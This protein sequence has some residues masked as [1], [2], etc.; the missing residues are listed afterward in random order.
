[1]V[2]ATVIARSKLGHDEDAGQLC[3]LG[4][5]LDE[6]RA[7][8]LGAEVKAAD[9]PQGALRLIGSSHG[10][11]AE[12][13]RSKV[14]RAFLSPSA[15]TSGARERGD[16][17]HQTL[18]APVSEALEEGE[19][20]AARSSLNSFFE[21]HGL[22]A[23]LAE[24]DLPLSFAALA[25]E[26]GP[27]P[28]D[29][30]VTV[31]MTT[32]N[33]ES[34]IQYSLGSVLAQSHRNLEVIVVDDGSTD[35][36]VRLVDE[37]AIRDDRVTRMST[38]H[39]SGTYAAKNLGLSRST[40]KYFTC[41]DSD[42]WAH[43][44]RIERHL[45]MMLA[46]PEVRA[47]RSAWFRASDR[48]EVRLNRWGWQVLEPNASS[49]FF[50]CEVAHEI[51]LFDEV[52]FGADSEY[53]GRVSAR[54]GP[55]A[56]LQEM[57]P[58]AVGLRHA[59][60]LTTSGV[61]AYDPASH[62]PLRAAYTMSWK[63]WHWST[64]ADHLRLETSERQF[65]A[66]EAMLSRPATRQPLSPGRSYRG[67]DVPRV[68]VVSLADNGRIVADPGME[69][70]D[71]DGPAHTWFHLGSSRT[72]GV[73]HSGHDPRLIPLVTGV[74]ADEP[75]SLA[76]AVSITGATV[77]VV[78]RATVG[79]D[80]QALKG[81]EAAIESGVGAGVPI[82]DNSGAVMGAVLPAPDPERDNQPE[83]LVDAVERIV[84]QW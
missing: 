42:D 9:D 61:G 46:H 41:H 7:A 49:A 81:V 17:H 43:P 32:Y 79:L 52:R 58:L 10:L 48:L 35:N 44:R 26:V 75:R 23:P 15:F 39:N 72:R 14:I 1:V 45:D 64:P 77:V 83:R 82:I 38:E 8:E 54:W 19:F 50:A 71:E 84:P 55:A 6:S 60:S 76:L 27:S 33:A 53:W 20:L 63:H 74:P 40:G 59:A 25:A 47:T 69:L 36:T 31:V 66:P 18:L 73:G 29:D 2:R 78:R 22:E 34:T 4:A 62:N 12:S 56:V 30:L 67:V 21:A 51:G 24:S 68:L 80:A 11:A 37:F 65:W 70:T 16:R 5:L 57:T 3:R 13:D 28:H